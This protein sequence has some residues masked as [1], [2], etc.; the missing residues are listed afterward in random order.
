MLILESI[1]SAVLAWVVWAVLMEPGMLLDWWERFVY[2][3]DDKG[4]QWLSKP[5]GVCGVCFSG[6]VGLW[7]YLIAYGNVWRL[8][9]HIAFMAQTIFFFLIIKGFGTWA[10]AKGY[11]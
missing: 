1:S 9:D 4:V 5:L 3:L 11:L 8:S 10:K 6:Q 7:F 2:R